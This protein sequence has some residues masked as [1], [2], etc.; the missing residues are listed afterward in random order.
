MRLPNG[1]PA[2]VPAEFIK[3][4]DRYAFEPATPMQPAAFDKPFQ[5]GG[6]SPEMLEAAWAP[7]KAKVREMH[8]RI[9]G[10]EQ[11]GTVREM[12]PAMAAAVT[13]A[14]SGRRIIGISGRAG[15]GKN[16]VAE[17]I[18]GAFVVQLADPLYAMISAMLGTPEPL[19]RR[20]EF[21]EA[22]VPWLGRSPRQLLQTLGTEWGRGQ[23]ADDIWIRLLDRRIKTLEEQGV[24]TIAVADVRFDNEA[25]HLRRSGGE[26]WHVRRASVEATDG[27]AS[28]AGV[29][30]MPHDVAIDNDGTLDDLRQAVLAAFS[31]EA[32]A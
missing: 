8:S 9:R 14:K 13:S 24:T 18:P 25:D 6:M 19:L 2:D 16:A 17:M 32:V 15:A 28:E 27:H 29:Q 26:V 11:P 7:V 30:A 1:L 20:R 4:N 21:K 10:Q 23:V 22:D 3:E 5:V 31:R 12:P